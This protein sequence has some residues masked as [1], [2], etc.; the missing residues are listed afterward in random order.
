[1]PLPPG[2][3]AKVVADWPLSRFYTAPR[4]VNPPNRPAVVPVRSS[5]LF[6]GPSGLPLWLEGDFQELSYRSVFIR[7]PALPGGEGPAC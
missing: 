5:R 3:W 7:A 2:R 1:V 6:S 4:T